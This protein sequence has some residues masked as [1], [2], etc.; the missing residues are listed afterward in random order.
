MDVTTR[1]FDK[2]SAAWGLTLNVPKTKL[3]VA[4]VGLSPDHAVPLQMSGGTI[5]VVKEF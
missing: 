2:V 4:G 3:L 5:E 1:V